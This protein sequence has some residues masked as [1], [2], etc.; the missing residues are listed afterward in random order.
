MKYLFFATLLLGATSAQAQFTL[1]GKIEYER[2]FNVHAMMK[3]YD[4][5]DA[6]VYASN[7]TNAF[8]DELGSSFHVPS[9]TP[10]IASIVP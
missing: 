6:I 2:K 4:D 10:S 8:Y 7:T 5:D 1:S 9:S 3:D